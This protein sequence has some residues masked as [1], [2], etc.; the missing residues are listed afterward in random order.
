MVTAWATA[1]ASVSGTPTIPAAEGKP[2]GAGA[3]TSQGNGATTSQG[4]QEENSE[5]VNVKKWP[6]RGDLTVGWGP[7]TESYSSRV[8][9]VPDDGSGL[10]IVEAVSGNA[11]TTIPSSVL[12]KFGYQSP[13][14]TEEM[15]GSSL[16]ESL[17]TRW[18]VR[19]VPAP[20][21]IKIGGGLKSS[22]QGGEQELLWTEV[23]LS[24]RFKFA[25]PVL[26]IAVGQLAGQK[27]DEMVE[28]FEERARRTWRR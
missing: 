21:G 18:T 17:V 27:V 26:G 10:G 3:T 19:S 14:D 2:R 20:G 13:S 16:F 6:S 1:P 28:A 7:F 15:E 23:A 8:Y 9:C 4:T 24:V 22:S 11:S 25:N 5:G 12:Q